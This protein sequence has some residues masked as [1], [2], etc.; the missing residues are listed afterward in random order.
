MQVTTHSRRMYVPALVHS[1]SQAVNTLTFHLS[2]SILPSSPSTGIE[3]R[4]QL[5]Q[6]T[7]PAN[8]GVEGNKRPLHAGPLAPLPGRL[9]QK[10][11]FKGTRLALDKAG[12]HF[13]CGYFL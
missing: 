3:V 2:L 12:F 13:P 6:L 10:P 7:W 9:S 5:A 11:F 4:L 8:K 1:I